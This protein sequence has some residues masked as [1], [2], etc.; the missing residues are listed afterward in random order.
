M[1]NMKVGGAE[2]LSNTCL[3]LQHHEGCCH[4]HVKVILNVMKVS[5]I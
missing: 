5:Q 2:H 1:P 3:H 4:V